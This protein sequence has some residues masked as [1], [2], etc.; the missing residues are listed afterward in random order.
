MESRNV[1]KIVVRQKFQHLTQT[2]VKGLDK[3]RKRHCVVPL[4]KDIGYLQR[5]ETLYITTP[6]LLDT[7]Y[8]FITIS[9]W[10]LYHYL[11]VKDID[12]LRIILVRQQVGNTTTIMNNL[13]HT[14]AKINLIW[15]VFK[16]HI[17]SNSKQRVV[18]HLLSN[19]VL[20]HSF[21][22]SLQTVSTKF[23]KVKQDDIVTSAY[24]QHTH[25]YAETVTS[26]AFAI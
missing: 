25:T 23:N 1:D 24:L 3:A 21:Q 10:P 18:R 9:N 20:K 22:P 2:H 7:H 16:S 26:L 17:K 5:W 15:K 4:N 14:T 19:S 12:K 11:S 13:Q 6:T 8:K